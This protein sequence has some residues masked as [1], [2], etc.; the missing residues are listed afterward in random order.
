MGNLKQPGFPGESMFLGSYLFLGL[1]AFAPCLFFHQAYYS[2]DLLTSFE[3]QRA[4]LRETIRGGFFPLWNPYLEGGTPFFANPVNMA[5]YPLNFATLFAPNLGLFFLLH[6][7]LAGFGMRFFLKQFSLPPAACFAGAAA[8]GLSN[9]F[10][11]EIIHPTHLAAFSWFPWFLACLE[12]GSREWNSRGAFGAGMVFSLLFLTGG[13]QI[14][15]ACFYAGIIYFFIRWFQHRTSPRKTGGSKKRLLGFILSLLGL[16]V[17]LSPLL[18]LFVPADEFSKQCTRRDPGN[19]YEN[20]N[21]LGSL[22]PAKT[23]SLFLSK[24]GLPPG[25]GSPSANEKIFQDAGED[26]FSS[27]GFCGALAPFFVFLAFCRRREKVF[28][29][30]ILFGILSILGAMGKYTP[31]HR[32]ICEFLPGF[33]LFRVPYRFIFLYV[34]AAAALGAFGFQYLADQLNRLSR[35]PFYA[36]LGFSIL[37]LFCALANPTQTWPEILALTAFISGLILSSTQKLSKN[38]LTVFFLSALTLPM[39]LNAWS[40]YPT[41]SSSI[42]NFA[43]NFPL[44]NQIRV[45]TGEFRTTLDSSLPYVVENG[46]EK[47]ITWFPEN[48]AGVLKI[49]TWGGYTTLTLKNMD[50]ILKLPLDRTAYLLGMPFLIFG[51]DKGNF[52]GLKHGILGNHH[53]YTPLKPVEMV[54]APR[55]WTVIPDPVQRMKAMAEADLSGY[56]RA[57]LSRPLPPEIQKQLPVEKINLRYSSAWEGPNLQFFNLELDKSALLVFSEAMFSGW[58]ARLDGKPVELFTADQALRAVFVPAGKR[59]LEFYFEPVWLKPLRAGLVLWILVIS[60]WGLFLW[61]KNKNTV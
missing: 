56:E 55:V 24:I 39:L 35:F 46:P 17:G 52:P 43:E 19:N 21:G 61:K 48:A 11:L 36:G 13:T 54:W 5:A 22:N 31:F 32:V 38:F 7:L 16:F 37:L 25:S 27:Y 51:E 34:F 12:L 28:L 15:V 33:S 47:V 41:A 58:K 30:L 40:L 60:I 26:F 8:Y 49:K 59:R 4:F 6:F 53:F 29:P 45:K 10:W 57:F 42:F 20:F 3:P 50:E 2:N 9:F 1:L 18:A 44:L 23:G 14:A